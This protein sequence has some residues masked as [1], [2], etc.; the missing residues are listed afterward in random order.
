MV[1]KKLRLAHR[2]GKFVGRRGA[3]SGDRGTWPSRPRSGQA[4]AVAEKAGSAGE[5]RGVVT[6]PGSVTKAGRTAR[7]ARRAHRTSRPRRQSIARGGFG[8]LPGVRSERVR[9]SFPLLNANT[10]HA[11][12]LHET[13]TSRPSRGGHS[14][15]GSPRDARDAPRTAAAAKVRTDAPPPRGCRRP[16]RWDR[17]PPRFRRRSGPVRLSGRSGVRLGRR[18]LPRSKGGSGRR[19]R[20]RSR[21]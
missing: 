14:L 4:V 5:P 1:R 18:S 11:Q 2:T 7:G 12:F 3:P 17:S 6:A 19:R 13:L 20:R 15:P 21:G 8:P 16:R 9:T 10:N